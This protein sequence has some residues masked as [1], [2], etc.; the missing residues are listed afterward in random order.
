MHLNKNIFNSYVLFFIATL[1]VSILVANRDVNNVAD[2]MNYALN[3]SNKVNFEI[4]YEFLFDFITYM[5][6]IF[7]ESYVIYFFV[8]NV[9]LNLFIFKT[10][11]NICKYLEIN[12]LNFLIYIFCLLLV[13][14][15][16]HSAAFNGLRQGLAL[17]LSYYAF[18]LYLVNGSK[19]KSFLLYLSSCFFHYS[20]FLILPFLILFKLSIDKL[21]ILLNILGV[22][23]IL[24]LNEFF[25]E[26]L[27]DLLSLPIYNEIK[28]YTEDGDMSYRY[29]FQL[30]LFIYTMFF[31]YFYWIMNRFFLGERKKLSSIIKIF[32]ILVLPYFIFGFAGYSNRYGVMAWFFSVFVNCTILYLFVMKKEKSVALNLF[33]LIFIFSLIISYLRFS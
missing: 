17:A 28:N 32:Y 3:F 9:I 29:G 21:F 19:I 22:F 18:T 10:S 2:T 16:Y 4:H 14:S 33:G 31:V 8:L 20:N 24:N 6:R 7:T 30:D 12:I 15:W 11:V 25:V 23:Y 5:V 27:S 1:L 26:K 13:S